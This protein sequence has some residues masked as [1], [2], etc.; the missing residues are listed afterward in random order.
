[1][2]NKKTLFDIFDDDP[3][4]LLNIKPSNNVARNE[5][6]R[7]VASFGEINDFYEKHQREPKAGGGIQEHQLYSRLQSIR[8]HSLKIEMLKPYD[9]HQLLKEQKVLTSLSDI[10]GDDEMNLL[11]G[12]D[13]GLY[14]L[15]H[16]QLPEERASADFVAKR[17]HCKDFDLYEASFKSVQNDLASGKRKLLAFKEQNLRAGD[18]YVH[19]GILM[20]LE[21]VD[22][23]EDIQPYKSGSRLRKDGRTRV[24]FENGTESNM[25]YRSLYKGLLANGKAVSENADKANEIFYERFG[26]ITEKD[27]E[28]GYIYVLKSKSTKPDIASIRHLYKIGYSTTK[29]EDRIKNASQEPTYLMG[30]VSIIIVYNCYNMNP[31][32]LEQLMHNF[33]GRWC[34]NLDVF[35]EFGQRHTPREW[36][37]APLYIIEQAIQLIISGEIVKY[38]YDG[39]REEI[40]EKGLNT[41]NV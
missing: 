29:V 27:R 17:K 32:K 10:F 39:D 16:V 19:N 15:K 2:A 12:D 33:F 30:D 22:F 23:K 14:D 31:Q 8:S 7:L 34:L 21:Q 20:Y 36:F 3:F 9:V 41:N 4:G 6:E 1:M 28:T 37:I 38:K 35:D 25:L 24:I 5:D 26:S 11:G 18:Y 13:M 40:V